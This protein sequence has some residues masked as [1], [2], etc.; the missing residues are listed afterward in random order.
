MP[1]PVSWL[2]IERG[3]EVVD[4]D[5]GKVGRV[6]ETLGDENADIFNGLVVATSLVGSP[7]YVSA[8]QVDEIRE[9]RVRLALS[10][11]EVDRLPRHEAS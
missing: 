8:E 9:G 11:A 10:P 3:W 6:E 4:R 1:D 2:V 5:G 7:R